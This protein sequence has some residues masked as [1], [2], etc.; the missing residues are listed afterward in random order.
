MVEGC[1][2]VLMP[3]DL[4]VYVHRSVVGFHDQGSR[5]YHGGESRIFDRNWIY[6]LPF[7]EGINARI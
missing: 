7:S 2:C 4:S 3:D 1:R 5:M 6:V